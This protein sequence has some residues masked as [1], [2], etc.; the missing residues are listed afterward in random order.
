M[1][2]LPSP[3]LLL[4]C[5]LLLFMHLERCK[6]SA[7]VTVC[8]SGIFNLNTTK[9]RQPTNSSTHTHTSQTSHTTHTP[10][11]PHTQSKLR[12][13]QS[14]PSSAWSSSSINNIIC[15]L[16]KTSSSASASLPHLLYV[17]MCV[18]VYN[19][20]RRSSS[21]TSTSVLSSSSSTTSSHCCNHKCNQNQ[22]THRQHCSRGEEGKICRVG[23]VDKEWWKR[24]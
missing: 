6:L 16:I 19:I 7:S 12:A 21:S 13:A 2:P 10:H 18:C 23:E 14:K 22:S 9:Q 11:T 5:A 17:C 8:K 24:G 3:P 20:Y 15:L 1:P 4:L